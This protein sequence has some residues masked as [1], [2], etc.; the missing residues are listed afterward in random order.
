MY[1]GI[2]L[3]TNNTKNKAVE[4]NLSCLERIFNHHTR[5][6]RIFMSFIRKT[7]QIDSSSWTFTTPMGRSTFHEH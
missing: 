2:F 3:S 6:E 5:L 7:G 1:L 4:D